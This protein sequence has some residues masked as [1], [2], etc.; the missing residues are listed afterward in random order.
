MKICTQYLTTDLHEA[1]VAAYAGYQVKF[2]INEKQWAIQNPGDLEE[3]LLDVNSGAQTIS[4]AIALLKTY[5]EMRQIKGE[6]ENKGIVVQPTPRVPDGRLWHV[7]SLYKASFM[8]Y[9]GYEQRGTKFSRTGQ[10]EFWF[11]RD[12]DLGDLLEKYK[13]RELLVEPEGFIDAFLAMKKI[14]NNAKNESRGEPT[15]D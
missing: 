2:L 13:K 14:M 15:H 6:S 9:A 12:G 7:T 3:F 4:N 1:A 8:L 5:D 11:S 10:L